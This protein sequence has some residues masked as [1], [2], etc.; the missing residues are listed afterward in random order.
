LR[1]RDGAW[2][3]DQD[4]LHMRLR[5]QYFRQQRAGAPTDIDHRSDRG[6]IRGIEE[7]MRIGNAVTSRP[8][9][10]VKFRRERRVRVEV[11]PEGT[12]EALM[13]SRLAGPYR[14]KKRTPGVGHAAAEVVEIEAEDR[15]FIQQHTRLLIKGEFAA[16]RFLENAVLH[17]V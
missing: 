1:T 5:A 16:Y 11:L 15:A 4:S 13:V 9:Y 7:H 3:I 12:A 8:H 6:P 14:R 10:C 17:Q 2:Q